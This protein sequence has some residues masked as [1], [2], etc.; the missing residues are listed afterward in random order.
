MRNDEVELLASP[1]ARADLPFRRAL[2]LYLDPFALFKNVN[3]GSGP[4]QRQALAY[5]RSHRGMLLAYA[6]RWAL[7]GIACIAAL[8]ALSS[9]ARAEP[10][11]LVPMLGLEIGFTTA[12]VSL[13]LSLAV[14][15]VL[16]IDN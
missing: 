5:N 10:A 8:L 16:G 4:A 6:K 15:V 12:V 1:Q 3:A 7:I 2:R 9:Y 11:L 13:L 14:Y